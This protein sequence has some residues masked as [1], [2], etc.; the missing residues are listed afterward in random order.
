M[1]F[2][3]IFQLV[4]S[5]VYGGCVENAE[6]AQACV[7]E[8]VGIRG[9][10]VPYCGSREEMGCEEGEVEWIGELGQKGEGCAEEALDL[11]FVLG[12]LV[13]GEDLVEKTVGRHGGR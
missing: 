6:H 4:A 1:V 2:V 13:V 11:A 5:D 7:A 3:C 12:S 8:R 9:M 10:A